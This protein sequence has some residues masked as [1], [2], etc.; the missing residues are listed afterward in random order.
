MTHEIYTNP[1]VSR[2]A[3]SEMKSLW[4]DDRKFQLWRQLWIAL[5][6]TQAELGLDVTD[7]QIAE[8]RANVDQID[9]QAIA[10]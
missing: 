5:A 2:Y 3:S 9:Y 1:L 6:E 10:A 4:S 7:Q 8:L